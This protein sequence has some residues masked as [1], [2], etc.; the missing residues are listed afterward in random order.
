MEWIT[1]IILGVVQG[2]TEF[3][4]ISSDGHLAVIG[5]VF[6]RLTG[7]PLV[8]D[9][10]EVGY[11]T[12][13]GHDPKIKIDWSDPK[14]YR[15]FYTK[16]LRL[17]RANSALHHAGM[18]DFR[19]IDLSPSARGYA[20]VRRD[21]ENTVLVVLNLSDTALTTK[22]APASNV[23]TIAGD[24]VDLFTGIGAHGRGRGLNPH[25]HQL[26][27][28]VR[29][30]RARGRPVHVGRGLNVWSNVH[31]DDVAELYAC[32]LEQAPAGSV[33]YCA[34]GEAS[35]RDMAAGV[36]KAIGLEGE[37]EA[38]SLEE[39]LRAFGIGAVTSFGSNSRVSAEKARRMLGWRPS[40]PTIWDDLRTDYYRT[41]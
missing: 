31:I 20:F 3:L 16:L 1:L 7:K 12:S 4:P 11:D 14:G 25:S 33:F 17:F 21:G 37:P 13:L 2:I 40:A 27:Q 15:A 30:A 35:W 24:Y 39:S 22:L 28:L 23:G 5:A 8:F 29:V 41:L 10:Q 9:G 36:G 18:A 32:A 34:N 19:K 26:P 38:L 6:E